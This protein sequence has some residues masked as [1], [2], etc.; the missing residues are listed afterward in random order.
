MK[1]ARIVAAILLA[2]P[3]LFFGGSYF[4][5]PSE[6]PPNEGHAGFEL[7]QL[8][9]DG[10][11]MAPIAASHVL[12]GILL[13]VPRTRFFGALVQLPMSIGILTFHVTMFPEGLWP[14]IVMLVLNLTVVANE[15]RLRGL[16]SN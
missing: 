7:I 8:M 3:L 14:A 13:L 10:G 9:R 6:L 5:A 1:W 2:L 11:L 15:E 16:F 4:V 12:V